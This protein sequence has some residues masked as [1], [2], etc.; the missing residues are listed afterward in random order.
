MQQKVINRITYNVVNL[1]GVSFFITIFMWF[2]TP[3]FIHPQTLNEYLVTLS[4]SL[5]VVFLLIKWDSLPKR[6]ELN[7]YTQLYYKVLPHTNFGDG[8]AIIFIILSIQQTIITVASTIEYPSST[9]DLLAALIPNLLVILAALLIWPILEIAYRLSLNPQ[10]VVPE[11]TIKFLFVENRP[12]S[13]KKG[14]LY[15]DLDK[16]KSIAE[17]EQSAADWRANTVSVGLISGISLIVGVFQFL[18]PWDGSFK[19][20]YPQAGMLLK[21]TYP[22]WGQYQWLFWLL[23]EI[24]ASILIFLVIYLLAR[25]MRTIINF[26]GSETPNRIVILACKEAMYL[27]EHLELDKCK[28][29]RKEF[30]HTEKKQ[31]AEYLGYKI[32]NKGNV[33][34]A[35]RG[36]SLWV[37]EDE[38]T[39][40]YLLPVDGSSRRRQFVEWI[41][42]TLQAPFDKLITFVKRITK[43]NKPTRR[44]K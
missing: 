21:F 7:G 28:E 35:E 25:W 14:L 17:I 38:S 6:K 40:F 12:Y 19:E 23:A 3:D 42:T 44:K 22:D 27:L 20:L 24:S 33:S 1:L 30:T 16:L 11:Y 34:F 36:N 13:T 43:N 31:I 4:L 15:S 5:I 29:K 26:I 41:F 32:V 10:R 18:G 8:L 37:Q 39:G 2:F 9:V